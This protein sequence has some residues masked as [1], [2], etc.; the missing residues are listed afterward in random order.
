MRDHP[1]R[2]GHQADVRIGRVE[3]EDSV[4]GSEPRLLPTDE[5]SGRRRG[6]LTGLLSSECTIDLRERLAGVYE[7]AGQ[8]VA[9]VESHWDDGH[10]GQGIETDRMTL[11]SL[12]HGRPLWSRT[13]V[14]HRFPQPTADRSF[15]PV[16]RTWELQ[17]QDGCAGALPQLGVAIDA[18]ARAAIDDALAQLADAERPQL[19]AVMET[20]L[21]VV[22]VA[23]SFAIFE[24]TL[25]VRGKIG[26]LLVILSAIVQ[27]TVVTLSTVLIGSSWLSMGVPAYLKAVLL[28]QPG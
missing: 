19:L 11:V 9:L 8:R 2:R 24:V 23:A 25:F 18:D 15:A 16:V 7:I 6:L 5:A 12:D 4:V 22:N 10:E 28:V 17:A 13:R 21:L 27:A 1:G 20:S 14:N 3:P 26:R